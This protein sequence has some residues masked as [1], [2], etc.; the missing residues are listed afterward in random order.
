M[1]HVDNTAE[2]RQVM[3]AY[4][5]AMIAA[6]TVRLDALVAPSYS[7][8]H[9]TGHVQSRK[10][11]FD[12]IRAS[13]FDYHS[14]RIDEKSVALDVDGNLARLSGRGI[15]DATING[16]HSPWRLQFTLQ[17]AKS[18]GIWRIYHARYASF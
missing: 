14:I 10:A 17:L 2:I 15:F 12:V 4:H 13:Q 11:W 16:A 3:S 18:Q 5:A 9:I 8:V 6:D 7:L 1:E